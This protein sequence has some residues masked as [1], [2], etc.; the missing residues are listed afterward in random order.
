MVE[1]EDEDVRSLSSHRMKE[2]TIVLEELEI[3]DSREANLEF[4]SSEES[5]Q[6]FNRYSHA[7]TQRKLPSPK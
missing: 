4:H 5:A 7:I 3:L 6:D 2:Q 1:V